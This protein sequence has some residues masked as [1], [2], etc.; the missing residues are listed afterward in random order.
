MFKTKLKE[1]LTACIVMFCVFQVQTATAVTALWDFENIVPS[2]LTTVAFE[3]TEGHVASNQSGINMYVIAKQGKF[4]QRTND[5]QFNA[6]TYL[7]VHCYSTSDVLTVTS[8]KGYH[9]FTVGGNAA[10]ADITSYTPTSTDVSNGWVEIKSTGSS[11]LKS[12]KLVTNGSSPSST[13]TVATALWDFANVNPSGLAGLTIEGKQGRLPS[14]LDG[15]TIYVIGQYGKFAQRTNDAQFNQKTTLR[16]PVTT[17]KDVVTVTSDPGYH[18]FNVGGVA[19]TADVTV[20]TATEAEV[21]QGYVVVYSFGASYLQSIKAV[22][23]NYVKPSSSSGNSSGG[24]TGTAVPTT[25]ITNYTIVKAG[26]ASGLLSAISKANTANKSESA[27]RYYIYLQNGTYDL[28]ETTLTAVTGHNISIIGQDMGSTIIKNAPSYTNEGISTT[29]TLLIKGK[30]T[31]LQDLTLQN[32]LDYYGHGGRAVALQDKGNRTICKN[33]RLLSYQDTYYSNGKGQYYWEGG[34]IHGTVDFICGGGDVFFNGTQITIEKRN[35]D[36]SGS[37]TITAPYTDSSNKGY[38]FSGC[39]IVNNAK[40]YNYGRAWGGKPRCAFISCILKDPGKLASSRWTTAGMNTYADKF[41]EYNTRNAAG[42]VVS[43]SSHVLTFTKGT[44]SNTIETILSATEAGTY[45]LAGVFADWTPNAYTAQVSMGTVSASGSKISWSKVSTASA[46]AIFK[47]NALL[48][49]VDA[50]TT[51]YTTSAAGTYS[52]RAAN[53]MG[54][55]GS[56]KSVT[57]SSASGGSSGNSTPAS[58]SAYDLNAPV[59]WG[60]VGGSI[61]G[62]GDNNSVTVTTMDQ[63][64][65]ALAGTDAKTIYVKG[66]LTTTSQ[67]SINGAQNK[68]VYGLPGSALANTTHTDNASNTGILYL[69]NCK[70]IILRNLTFKGPGAY[71]IDGKDNLTVTNCQYIWV[72]HCDFQDA[73]DGNFDCNNGSDNIS[74]TWCRFRY[75]KAPYAGGSGGSDDHR[76][77]NLWGGGDKVAADVGHLNTTFANCWWDEGCKERMPRVRNGKIHIVN[78]LY[79]SSAANYCI[80]AGYRSNIYVENS[81]FTSSKTQKGAW[82]SCATSSGYTD[83]NITLTGC[84]GAGDQQ[85]RSGSNAYF[86]PYSHYSYSP[87][88]ANLV[89]SAVSDANTGAGA[90]LNVVENSGVMKKAYGG[91]SVTGD[92]EATAITAAVTGKTLVSTR[93]FNA[94]GTEVPD[95]QKGLNVI[96]YQYSDGTVQTKKVMIK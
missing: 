56:L 88:A 30:N 45:S 68:T 47:D 81:A 1:I 5:A 60:T 96:R 48:A 64:K 87:Y 2:S 28:G 65:N 11:Y 82:K 36:G 59:G 78:C 89:E 39:T 13:G 51:S 18:N 62:S 49:I 80:G 57:V 70:N 20:H 8:A 42:S 74:V 85:K 52:V 17:T 7:R 94:V 43:P 86:N 3:G 23:N 27:S 14:T 22:L 77:S 15:I 69:K 12:I 63:L 37:C 54:G 41:A 44:G 21:A 79:S 33:V 35:A 84:Q 83:Y 58:L 40:S 16:V 32:A 67:V 19:A 91:N 46:Y 73:C 71:D 29:A 72:D 38:I 55:L 50:N 10:T 34:D 53:A 25:N 93:Y 9:N 26:D 24:T 4:K 90:T 6:N 95:M 31:Y 66:T 76:F 92:S 75:L 61:T